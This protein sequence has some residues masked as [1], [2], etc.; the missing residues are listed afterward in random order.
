MVKENTKSNDIKNIDERRSALNRVDSFASETEEAIKK[1]EVK[2]RKKNKD[3]DIYSKSLFQYPDV[4]SDVINGLAFSGESVAAPEEFLE[5]VPRTY[6]L[7]DGKTSEQ[8]RDVVKRWVHN[9]KVKACFAI[10]N[11][12]TIDA[13]MPIRVIGYDGAEYRKQ[14]RNIRKR[15]RNKQ[16]RKDNHRKLK[17]EGTSLYPVITMV[18]YYSADKSWNRSTSL[19]DCLSIEDG[20]SR[21]VSDYKINVIDIAL[22]DKK[23][24]NTFTSDFRILA[25]Y[26]HQMRLEGKFEPNLDWIVWHPEELFG[27][28]SALTGD[29][30]YEEAYYALSE[31]RKTKEIR[32][33]EFL[34]QIENRGIEKGRKEGKSEGIAE[35]RAEG[36]VEG[37]NEGRQQDIKCLMKNGG[38]SLEAA[39]KLLEIPLNEKEYYLKTVC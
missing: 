11:Q 25:E 28:M 20:L 10:E 36:K 6:Y 9:G 21:Y 35:G 27:L 23:T 18:L 12:T 29:K 15:K 19:F 3:K 2:N 38:F 13:D 37:R 16:W 24:I 17:R 1:D 7:A 4:F 26:F 31:D 33:C 14:I 22:L 5:Q 30:R 39:M 8:E 34:D 32:M